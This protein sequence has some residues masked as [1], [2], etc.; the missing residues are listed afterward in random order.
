MKKATAIIALALLATAAHGQVGKERDLSGNQINAE[1]YLE[2]AKGD[3][4]SHT[5][6][7]K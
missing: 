2:I 4:K 7:N 1:F 3:V 6:V 5:V